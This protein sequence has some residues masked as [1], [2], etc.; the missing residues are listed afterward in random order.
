MLIGFVGRRCFLYLYSRMTFFSSGD[1][2]TV[3]DSISHFNAV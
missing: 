1:A 2:S 3:S